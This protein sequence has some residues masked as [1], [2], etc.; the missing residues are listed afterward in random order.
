MEHF[1][2][3]GLLDD[4][5]E[6]DQEQEVHAGADSSGPAVAVAG[7]KATAPGVLSFGL[8]G[9]HQGDDQGGP[10]GEGRGRFPQPRS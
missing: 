8:Y 7:K 9:A 3:Y 2:R 6:E 4:D 10:R 5:E 1:S